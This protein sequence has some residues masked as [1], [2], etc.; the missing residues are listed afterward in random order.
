SNPPLPV[1]LRNLPINFKDLPKHKQ[2]EIH[3][4]QC[5]NN[6]TNTTTTH[7]GPSELARCQLLAESAIL[8]YGK[9]CLLS[10]EQQAQLLL[11]G[12]VN[13]CNL[14]IGTLAQLGDSIKKNDHTNFH[15]CH[16]WGKPSIFNP[17]FL[18]EANKIKDLLTL[19]SGHEIPVCCY[20][21]ETDAYKAAISKASF[22]IS[23]RTGAKHGYVLDRDECEEAFAEAAQIA[24][25]QP[26]VTLGNGAHHTTAGCHNAMDYILQMQQAIKSRQW[27]EAESLRSKAIRAGMVWVVFYDETK[28]DTA[29]KAYLAS[30]DEG[31]NKQ[32]SPH[33]IAF[34][35]ANFCMTQEE[36]FVKANPALQDEQDKLFNMVGKTSLSFMGDSHCHLPLL[37][38]HCTLWQLMFHASAFDLVLDCYLSEDL[39]KI[40][41]SHENGGVVTALVMQAMAKAC[42]IFNI[43]VDFYEPGDHWD[44]FKAHFD[45]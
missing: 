31:I 4:R 36:E 44:H 21:W 33:E 15:P 43:N 5:T 6:L 27:D 9:Y 16:V 37:M 3:V 35:L 12:E 45:E 7:Q 20:V 17:S 8:G 32:A 22:G 28:L 23:Y 2:S 42:M 13:K 29:T 41:A 1:T 19:E 25:G 11:I 40:M 30:G 10:E 14:D 38:C 34:L 18:K 24:S 39:V 26:V